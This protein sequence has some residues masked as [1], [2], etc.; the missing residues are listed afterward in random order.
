MGDLKVIRNRVAASAVA[1]PLDWEASA[2]YLCLVFL[3]SIPLLVHV[4]VDRGAAICAARAWDRGVQG[5]LIQG[6]I[7]ALLF[8]TI[9]ML[10]TAN[11]SDC[12]YFRF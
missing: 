1:T 8:A 4:L 7:A 6:A 12:I 3:Y 5:I 2:Y 10:R 11:L 9:L